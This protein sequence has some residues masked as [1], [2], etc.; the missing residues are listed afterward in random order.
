MGPVALLLVEGGEV[1]QEGEG[2]VDWLDVER[3]GGGGLGRGREVDSL[4]GLAGTGGRERR[5]GAVDCFPFS[6]GLLIERWLAS[7]NSTRGRDPASNRLLLPFLE[8]LSYSGNGQSHPPRAIIGPFPL[9]PMHH[10]RLPTWLAILAALVSAVNATALYHRIYHPAL[11]P[12]AKFSLRGTVHEGAV[13]D[14]SG[15]ETDLAT[16]A[17]FISQLDTAGKLDGA[18]YQLALERK[19]DLLPEDWIL[20]SVKAVSTSLLRS[21][22][23]T[24]N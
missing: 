2:V 22:A 24:A 23:A 7:N 17:G 15:L 18:L 20:S 6:A 1:V 16:F 14:A 10:L 5:R 19:S 3:A 4:H 8:I 13:V 9:S 12:T 11:A 21:S